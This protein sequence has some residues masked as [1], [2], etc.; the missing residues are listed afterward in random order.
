MVEWMHIAQLMAYDL[1]VITQF[2]CVRFAVECNDCPAS[3]SPFYS[4]MAAAHAI[5]WF[6]QPR[7]YRSFAIRLPYFCM[8]LASDTSS[9]AKVTAA[10]RPYRWADFPWCHR[11]NTPSSP[12]TVSARTANSTRCRPSPVIHRGTLNGRPIW[13]RRTQPMALLLCCQWHCLSMHRMTS[14]SSCSNTDW[15]KKRIKMISIRWI[16]WIMDNSSTSI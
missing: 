16:D 3:I 5:N 8:S 14:V 10:L 13:L 1:L 9:R 15:A 2:T 6:R 12:N 7:M 11:R 4:E